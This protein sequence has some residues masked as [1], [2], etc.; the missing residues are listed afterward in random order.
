MPTQNQATS[1][2]R[3]LRLKGDPSRV[4]ETITVW[5][6]HILPMIKKQRGFSGA[7]LAGNRKSG[8][9][10]DVSYSETEAAMKEARGQVRPQALKVLAQ[11]GA[12][13]V[14]TMSAKSHSWNGSS[15][16]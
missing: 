15:H 5:S 16:R 9:A 10:L 14:R 4:H 8:D 11:I 3:V 1:Y 2:A 13:I 12:S 7:T 6:R